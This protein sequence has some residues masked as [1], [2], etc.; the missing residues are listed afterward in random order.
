[1]AHDHQRTQKNQGLPNLTEDEAR[2]YIEKMRWPDGAFCPH[3]ASVNVYRMDGKSIRPGLHACRDCRGHFTVTVGTVMEDSHLPLSK[4]VMAF[5]MVATSKKGISALQLQRNLGIG[6][7]RTAW[8]LAHRIREA[9]RC[10]SVVARLKGAVQVDE[11]YIG[12]KPRHEKGSKPSKRGAGTTKTPVVALIETDGRAHCEPMKQVTAKNL[13]GLMEKHAHKTAVIVT[14]ELLL[15]RNATDSFAG[16]ETVNHG[17]YEYVNKRGFTTN[18]AESYFALLKRGVHGTF[19][20]V[21]KQHL[22]RYCDEFSFR[23]NGR[24]LTDTD[25]RNEAVRG[26]EGKRLFLYQP[27]GDA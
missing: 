14:D 17:I 15:Y 21:G 10:D 11:A 8:H 22:H 19:H 27:A 4:W 25:R 7:Y 12:G 9:M 23:W 18:G 5:H 1:M 3:C 20:H 13:R 16:H 24:K 6:S 2:D 26:I